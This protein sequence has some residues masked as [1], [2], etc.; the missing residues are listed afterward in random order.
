MADRGEGG[1]LSSLIPHDF[2]RTAVRNLN[3][4]GVPETVAMK[5]TG[6]KTRSVFDRYDI[7]SE[8]DLAEA[9]RKLRA[10][11][12]GTISGTNGLVDADALRDRIAKSVNQKGL[13]VAR[14]RIELSTLR[15]SVVCST[16]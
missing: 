13:L 11:T 12:M 1:R 10:L 15:F 14:D 16:N 9:S 3:R 5:I 8:E 4:A 2:R 7:T 6:H